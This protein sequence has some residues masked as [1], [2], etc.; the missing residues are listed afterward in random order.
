[1]KGKM[2][3]KAGARHILEAIAEVEKYLAGISYDEFLA[4]SEKAFCY[5]KAN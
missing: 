3:D 1:M 4:N 2:T 5:N